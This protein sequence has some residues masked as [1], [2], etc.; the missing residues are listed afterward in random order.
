M[1]GGALLHLPALRSALALHPRSR[2]VAAR[3]AP[4]IVVDLDETLLFR[5]R[6][7]LDAAL[8][9]AAPAALSAAHVGR[10]YEAAAAAV[11]GLALHFRIVAVTARHASAERATRLWL[12]EHGLGG[13]PLVLAAGM[14]PR[15][16][17]RVAYKRAAIRLL[18]EEGWRPVLGVGDRPSDLQAYAREGLAAVMVAHAQGAPRGSA[19]QRLRSPSWPR[20]RAASGASCQS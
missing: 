19:A 8:L 7:L 5:E 6:G 20:S 1:S 18:R 13:L 16:A 11:R 12:Q 17:S 10:P 3:L 9:Y 4:T 2:F 15:D 14:H